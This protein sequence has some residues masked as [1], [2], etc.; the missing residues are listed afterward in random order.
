M[1]ITGGDEYQSRERMKPFA[2]TLEKDY[3]F[4]VIYIEDEA[5]GADMDPD[6]DPK[7]TVLKNAEKKNYIYSTLW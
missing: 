3:G 2:R 5:P 7:P 4:D 1:F 6:N